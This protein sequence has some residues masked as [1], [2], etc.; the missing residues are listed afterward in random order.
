ME[1]MVGEAIS[2]DVGVREARVEVGVV[3]RR[4]ASC[5]AAAT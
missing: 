4:W 2:Q 3:E 5:S 1:G